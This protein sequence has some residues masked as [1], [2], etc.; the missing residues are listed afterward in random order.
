MFVN[1]S[2]DVPVVVK[3]EKILK[4]L[5]MPAALL[6]PEG[7]I[8]YANDLYAMC[9]GATVEFLINKTLREL[10][11]F[12]HENFMS[13]VELL[14]Q[15]KKI[16]PYEY[17]QLGHCYMVSLSGNYNQNNELVSILVC[18]SDIT[19]IK[20]KEDGLKQQNVE[21]KKLSEYDHLTGLM[22]RRSY[23][24]H[25]VRYCEALKQNQLRN[26]SLILIDIDNFKQVNDAF[27]HIVGDEVI[28]HLSKMLHQVNRTCTWR[29]AYRYGGEEFIILLTES[30]LEEACNLAE[31]I[32][33]VI[34]NLNDTLFVQYGINVT[35]SCGVVSSEEVSR[36]HD[37]FEYADKAM[38]YAKKN[39]KN[40]VY[41]FSQNTYKRFA[42]EC[43]SYYSD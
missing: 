14:K 41:Y 43:I 33:K 16:E 20:H 12:A 26:L 2:N 4:A 29:Q 39:N 1:L 6:T 8:L 13:N 27:G 9:W 42:A 40:C 37:F 19:N 18:G 17:A 21:L 36:Q 31:H 34:E 3:T 22:N 11:F 32:R 30:V 23:D 25:Y 35:I 5:P 7:R 15:L 28:C 38:Y 10:S 24:D